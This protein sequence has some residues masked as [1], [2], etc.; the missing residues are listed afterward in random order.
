MVT[1][2][3]CKQRRGR[4]REGVTES[5]GGSRLWAVSTEPDEGLEPTD[6]DIMTWAKVRRL[7]DRATQAP[8]KFTIFI[9]LS[10]CLSIY[11]SIYLSKDFKVNSVPI[12]GL[13]LTTLR[14]RVACFHPMSHGC[15]L[16]IVNVQFSGSRYITIVVQP[17]VPSIS[18]TLFNS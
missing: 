1:E 2:T 13:K 4:E 7:T 18:R 5:K 16:T 3:E 8:P 11:L 6:R 14:S 12:L 15:S 9:I 10:V 17:L